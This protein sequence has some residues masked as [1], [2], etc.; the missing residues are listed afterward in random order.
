MIDRKLFW[1]K[2]ERLSVRP[3][4][5][6]CWVWTG[7]RDKDGYGVIHGP[8]RK[9]LKSHR[10]AFELVHG[11]TK[12]HVLHHCDNPPCCRPRHLFKGTQRANMADMLRKGRKAIQ[13]G[14]DA[15][16]AKLT[17]EQVKEIRTRRAAGE[18]GTALA[19]E[20]GVHHM[21]IYG[22]ASG[23]YWRKP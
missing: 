6:D 14:E 20:Y 15:S 21:S 10:V 17:W 11:P 12:L 8:G 1:A 18:S 22:I 7:A 4:L 13:Y 23:K 16:R 2:T 5:G 9:F 3:E 19:R